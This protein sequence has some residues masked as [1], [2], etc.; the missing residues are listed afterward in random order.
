MSSNPTT[1]RRRLASLAVALP[2]LGGTTALAADLPEEVARYV[3]LKGAKLKTP[4]QD[5]VQIVELPSGQLVR[6]DLEHLELR[7]DQIFLDDGKLAELALSPSQL[8]EW[9]EIHRANN[10][11]VIEDRSSIGAI[12][13]TVGSV[14]GTFAML[15]TMS[16][17]SADLLALS[18]QSAQ[19]S[20]S[21]ADD[22]PALDAEEDALS[23]D[24]EGDDEE[25]TIVN[26]QPQLGAA[27]TNGVA[28]ESAAAGTSTGASVSATDGDGGTLEYSIESQQIDGAF[29]VDSDT[30]E[31][32][33]A[34]SAVIDFEKHQTLSVTVAV[35]DGQ[36]GTASQEVTIA[37]EDDD[38]DTISSAFSFTQ[39]HDALSSGA[40]GFGDAST[41]PEELQARFIIAGIEADS[42]LAFIDQYIAPI[43]YLVWGSGF[44]DASATAATFSEL[45]EIDYVEL[46]FGYFYLSG[47]AD[48]SIQALSFPATVTDFGLETALPAPMHFKSF[49]ADASG[50]PAEL[51]AFSNDTITQ[52]SPGTFSTSNPVFNIV[53]GDILTFGDTTGDG[54]AEV[55]IY[56]ASAT[57]AQVYENLG[58]G[59]ATTPLEET[60]FTGVDLDALAGG[61]LL[62][63]SVSD[64]LS[65]GALNVIL[66]GESATY[67]YELT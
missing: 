31:I 21:S 13:S 38:S 59:F 61:Q 8:G 43:D 34:N 19:A 62:D 14:V 46:D 57:E 29:T 36:G 39:T 7:D 44:T 28:N 24:E 9:L 22:D 50:V 18:S 4:A 23:E 20:T 65:N 53:A 6:V 66:L 52:T 30:G 11:T 12:A 35:S 41:D 26:V 37:I 32:S 67:F 63:M 17:L 5:G 40:I 1:R 48:P 47:Y 56:G 64:H 25:E 27:P 33:V 45:A 15:N 60:I 42:G 51:Y 58:T 49:Y 55:I 2:A 16:D 54:R 10:V 3:E